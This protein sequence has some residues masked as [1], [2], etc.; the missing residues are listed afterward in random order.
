[1]KRKKKTKS[2]EGRWD[3]G[4]E[5]DQGGRVKVRKGRVMIRERGWEKPGKKQ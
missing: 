5:K 3:T 1:V 2:R 4:G